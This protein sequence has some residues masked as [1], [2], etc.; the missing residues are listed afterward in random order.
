MNSSTI[1]VTQNNAFVAT[2]DLSSTAT[3]P[4]DGLRFAVKDTIDVAALKPV[5]VIR[6]GAIPIPPL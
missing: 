3:G 4:L 5:V 6:R 1:T 2:F